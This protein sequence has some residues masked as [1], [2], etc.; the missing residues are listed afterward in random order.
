MASCNLLS[1]ASHTGQPGHHVDCD[2][3]DGRQLGKIYHGC[4]IYDLAVTGG[5]LL[6]D[7]YMCRYDN[8]ISSNLWFNINFVFIM[9]RSYRIAPNFISI[10]F[11]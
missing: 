8:I 3:S 11:S 10:I 4:V 1:V 5:M 6:T 7:L 9:H 2:C